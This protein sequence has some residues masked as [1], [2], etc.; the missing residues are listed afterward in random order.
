MGFLSCS[1]EPPP[2][3]A[4]SPSPGVAKLANNSNTN[5]LPDTSRLLQDGSLGE[6]LQKCSLVVSFAPHCR[7]HPQ[8]PPGL[9]FRVSN[10]FPEFNEWVENHVN[11]M[12]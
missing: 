12:E 7:N 1:E 4:D 2:S 9:L 5:Y 8:S 11:D 6:G 3:S 10:P